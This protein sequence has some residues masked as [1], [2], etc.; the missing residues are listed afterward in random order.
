[1][2]VEFPKDPAVP[3]QTA[4]CRPSW[5]AVMDLK[6]GMVI[7]KTVSG[8]WGGYATMTLREGGVITE[9][10]IAQMVVKNIECVAVVNT[11]PPSEGDYAKEM[12]GYEERLRQIFEPAPNAH[13]EGLLNAML[14]RG[15]MPC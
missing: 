10:T 13:C 6:P 3:G 1:M 11:D 12:R 15:P 2:S 4:R 5:K 8:S 9:E 14:Q 7:A